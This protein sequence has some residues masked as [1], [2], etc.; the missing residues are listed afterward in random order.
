M[1]FMSMQSQSRRNNFANIS[2]DI[3]KM[4]EL[5]PPAFTM[6]LP[7]LAKTRKISGITIGSTQDNSL[8]LTAIGSESPN[9][10][11]LNVTASC[12][13]QPSSGCR[14]RKLQNF[15]R[16]AQNGPRKGQVR[17]SLN[18]DS[19]FSPLQTLSLTP[20]SIVR[21]A[22][23]RK[24]QSRLANLSDLGHPL[25]IS[26]LVE[27]KLKIPVTSND[28]F[29][30]VGPSRIVIPRT[31]VLSQRKAERIRRPKSKLAHF[32]VEMK[33]SLKQ[34]FRAY[35]EYSLRRHHVS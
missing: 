6:Q 34:S 3:P 5:N 10:Q 11:R 23:Q 16:I 24:I 29:I 12:N 20:E 17:R 4:Q 35:I 14:K 21:E 32:G 9:V 18:R 13:D 7:Q 27:N 31:P 1:C 30:A 8:N 28:R 33:E 25:K 2:V 26:N 19:L 15:L 22:K